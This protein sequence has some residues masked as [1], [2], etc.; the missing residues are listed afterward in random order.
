MSRTCAPAGSVPRVPLGM[1]MTSHSRVS[2]M[3]SLFSMRQCLFGGDGL[4]GSFER[5]QQRVPGER[6][7]LDADGKLGDAAEDGE[8]AHVGGGRAR[9][10]T[11]GN[12]AMELLENLLHLG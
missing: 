9:L 1:V 12:E 4:F 6:G 8:L 2:A 10:D 3:G 5:G 11:A 7:A